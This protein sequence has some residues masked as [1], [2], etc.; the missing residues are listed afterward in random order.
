MPLDLMCHFPPPPEQFWV[1]A[2][3]KPEV[4]SVKKIVIILS[5]SESCFVRELC[6]TGYKIVTK[7]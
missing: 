1:L 2:S 7:G 5:M 6:L 3:A 4:I